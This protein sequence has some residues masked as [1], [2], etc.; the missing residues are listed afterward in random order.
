MKK[1]SLLLLIL[2]M[3]G[4]I[5]CK[6]S[7]PTEIILEDYACKDTPLAPG[8]Y[9]PSD[10][11]N[12]I[13]PIPD[14]YEIS[15]T[16]ET[17]RLGQMPRNW[18]LYR[19]EEY[20][21]DGVKALVVEADDNRYVELYSDGKKA[22]MYPQSAPTPTFI[23]TTK[24]NLDQDRKGVAYA[25]L[26]LP[27]DQKANEISLGVSTGAVNTIAIVINSTLAI[28]VKTGGPF[29][30]HSGTGDG[31]EIFTTGYTIEKGVW[32]SFKYE[33]DASINQV[34]VSMEV[35]DEFIILHQ[36]SFHVSNRVN[37]LSDGMILV[38]NVFKITMPQNRDGYAYIDDIIVTRKE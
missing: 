13:S 22:P 19:N 27:E 36:G 38:P 4:L 31:G 2:L 20:A 7:E 18:L 5:G 23:F 34:S 12:F 32:Y 29:F 16:F 17:D 21:T 9:I 1:Y 33:W 37:A 6:K 25:R 10:D 26:M 30:Y 3:I 15:E 35:D 11:L 14:E 8:C 28:Q 24:F